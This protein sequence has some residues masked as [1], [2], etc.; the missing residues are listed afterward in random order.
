MVFIRL[1]ISLSCATI[2]LDSTKSRGNW[3]DSERVEDAGA[4]ASIPRGGEP[5]I[6]MPEPI[7]PPAFPLDIYGTLRP[8]EGR[9]GAQAQVGRLRPFVLSPRLTQSGARI[10]LR[11]RSL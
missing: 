10:R 1:N 2:P 6:A 3:R 5:D 11:P 8:C 7:A 9:P 4:P